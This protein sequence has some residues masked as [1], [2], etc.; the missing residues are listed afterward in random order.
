MQKAKPKNV[1]LCAEGA[2]CEKTFFYF[3]ISQLGF[4]AM[5]YTHFRTSIRTFHAVCELTREPRGNSHFI[6]LSATG[7]GTLDLG[8]PTFYSFG[9][10]CRDHFGTA[11]TH[12]FPRFPRENPR[13][14][15]QNL[16]V[17]STK[18]CLKWAFRVLKS[19]KF[20]RRA[21]NRWWALAGTA[22]KRA[23]R[24]A[25]A[26][27]SPPEYIRGAGIQSGISHLVPE[28][29]LFVHYTIILSEVVP[30]I[31]QALND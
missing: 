29:I 4:P 9:V 1:P 19:Q 22:R 8:I 30:G 24:R 13:E 23:A 25:S 6:I 10:A 31:C 2:R 11:D 15:P 16:S 26:A 20:P 18:L 28:I 5:V 21:P 3:H 12:D 14:K 17:T 27:G 7:L